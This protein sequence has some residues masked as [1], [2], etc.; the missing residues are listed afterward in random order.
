MSVRQRPEILNALGKP[1]WIV[2][3]RDEYGR[4][5]QIKTNSLTEREAK[6]I[7]ADLLLKV[8]RARREKVS[9]DALNPVT[10]ST[11]VDETYLPWIK[12]EVKEKTYKRYVVLTGHLKDYFGTMILASIKPTT[13]DDEFKAM[14]REKTIQGRAPGAGELKNRLNQLGA[15]LDMAIKKELL[16]TA[17]PAHYANRIRYTPKKKH[18]ITEAEEEKILAAAPDWLKPIIVVGLYGGM[19][20]AEI[21]AIKWEH[22]GEDY[23]VIPAENSKTG[24]TRYIPLNAE[25]RAAIGDRT[26]RRLEEGSPPWVFYSRSRKGPF[27]PNSVSMAFKRVASGLSIPATF[28][29]TRVAFVTS[30]RNGGKIKDVHLKAITGHKTDQMLEHYTKVQPEHLIGTTEGLRRSKDATQVQHEVAKG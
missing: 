17:N 11:F 6:I 7:E 18:F 1:A 8:D 20:E 19:R 28:H 5:K 15:I 10:F 22:V 16:R 25:I 2:D 23:I 14:L 9:V 4:R 26:S 12:T 13:V 27:L 24:E 29:C 30:A 21:T 3:Y